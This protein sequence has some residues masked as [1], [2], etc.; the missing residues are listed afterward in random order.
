MWKMR[1]QW[2]EADSDWRVSPQTKYGAA[3]GITVLLRFLCALC[4]LV[5]KGLVPF[6]IDRLDWQVPVC[7]ENLE[8]ALLFARVGLLVGE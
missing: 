5:V 8:A 6:Q 3:F 7:V 4:V 2:G 1:A